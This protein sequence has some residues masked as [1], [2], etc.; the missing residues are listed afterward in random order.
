[1]DP[2][3]PSS[4]EIERAVI[5]AML[6]EPEAI[7]TAIE[8]LGT[9]EAFYNPQHQVVYRA[10]TDLYKQNTPADQITLTE[11]L[12]TRKQLEYIG[13][14]S[15]VAGLAGEITGAANV[16]HY[17]KTLLDKMRGRLGISGMVSKVK[18]L[19]SGTNTEQIISEAVAYLM[20]LLDKTVT[21]PYRTLREIMP[22]VYESIQNRTNSTKCTGIP[23]GLSALDRYTDGWQPGDLIIVAAKT[24]QGKTALSLNFA[25][26]A[27]RQGFPVGIFSMEMSDSKLGTRMLS[28]ESGVDLA[29]GVHSYTQDEFKR[30]CNGCGE[31]SKLPVCIDDTPGLTI[32][33]VIAKARR[34]QRN[35]DIKM[36]IVDYLQLAEGDNKENRQ[37]EVTSISRGLKQLARAIRVPVIALSQFS[38]K[39]DESDARRP[40]LSDLRESGAIEQDADLVIFIHNATSKEKMDY[41]CSGDKENIRE[42][43]IPKNRNGITGEI[44]TYWK[45]DCLTFYDVEY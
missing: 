30:L 21:K 24:S 7:E 33:Q 43:I 38:R 13:G 11:L 35:M 9:G 25:R 31:L 44:L 36:V 37:I 3:F 17:C 28:A 1:M 20:G 19:E 32:S 6:F 41:S 2:K 16:P 8:L 10:I 29:P 4:P 39:A 27:A 12:Q 22:D 34:M 45:K 15:Y 40:R 18:D 5:G 23:T 26:H 42:L 14:E